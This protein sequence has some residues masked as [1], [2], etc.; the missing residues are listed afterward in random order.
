MLT[1]GGSGPW[2]GRGRSW[3]ESHQ[4]AGYNPE[5]MT[6]RST[7]CES[8]RLA[9]LSSLPPHPPSTIS[10][11]TRKA[12]S[13]F[14][15]NQRFSTFF[16]KSRRSSGTLHGQ[17]GLGPCLGEGDPPLCKGC[18]ISLPTPKSTGKE[19]GK[20][21]AALVQGVPEWRTRLPPLAP[22]ACLPHLA[23]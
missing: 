2:E 14:S 9:P 1:R 16:L 11:S 17:E 4:C 19:N 5:L 20:E 23:H 10:S 18:F 12:P 21:K 22:L 6:L 8:P 3:P 13:M 7:C 15:S